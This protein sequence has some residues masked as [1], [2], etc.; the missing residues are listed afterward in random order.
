M[1]PKAHLPEHRFI[2]GAHVPL[3]VERHTGH[4]ALFAIRDEVEERDHEG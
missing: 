3:E 2:F 1:L 4:A